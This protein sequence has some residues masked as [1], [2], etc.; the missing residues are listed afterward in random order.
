[1]NKITLTTLVGVMLAACSGKDSTT[2]TIVGE[3]EGLPDSS[4]VVL[5]PLAHSE[6]APITEATV[7]NG[8][9][10]F[11]GQV[12]EPIAVRLNV[13]DSYGGKTFM[14]ENT[15]MKISGMVDSQSSDRG[16][17]Y[18]FSGLNVSGSPLTD[19]YYAMM[20][21]RM[22]LDSIMTVNQSQVAEL[23]AAYY[24]ARKNND[25]Q[26][27]DSIQSSPEFKHYAEVEKYC[28]N[29]FDSVLR[30]TVE[31]N[32]NTIWAPIA[33]LSQLS[34]LSADQRELYESFSEEVKN[35]FHGRIVG[36]ELYPVGRPGDK[37]PEFEAVT[38]DGRNTNLAAL[39]KDKKY[40]LLDF[41]ASW[42]GP[43]RREIPNLKEIYS[44]FSDKGFD[45]VSI[46]IDKEEKPWLNAVKNEDL[47][48]TN[49]RDGEHTIAD[50]Y[51][52]TAVPTMY[53]VDSEGRL[54]GENLRGEELAAKISELIGE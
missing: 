12:D 48:W 28:F 3:V 17:F 7:I 54:V 51:K 47:K 38:L 1:M 25:R 39:C 8:K 18:G 22:R 46:S 34:Y 21:P 6:M 43:C 19:E 26:K 20:A 44:K 11:T 24:D 2:Y 40:V 49:I 13:K 14:L 53:I 32:K 36:E 4:V 31:Q 52:V 15:D 10:K 23:M 29:G 30:A 16:T 9:F 37:L 50:K 27:V 41:W 42:C 45:I 33:M 5:T 35:S